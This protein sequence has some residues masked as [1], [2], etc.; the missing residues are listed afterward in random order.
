MARRIG[1]G[2]LLAAG[3]AAVGFFA[4]RPAPPNPIIGMVR[5]TEVKIAPEVSGRIA[6]L[7]V[8]AGDLVTAGT[9]VAEL[10]N[11]ELAA[12]VSEAEAAVLAARATRDRVYAGIRQEEVDIAAH[13]IE[14][15]RAD[16]TLAKAQL[17]R[18]SNL[19]ATGAGSQ[20]Q[21]DDARAAEATATARLTAAQLRHAEAESG[22]TIEE[23]AVADA[24]VVVAEAS[25]AVLKQRQGKLQI[26]S[27]TDGV[28]EVVVGELGEATVPGRTILTIADARKFWFS[29]NIREDQLRGL[30]IGEQLTLVDGKD[31]QRFSAQVSEMR[32]LGD[33]ATWRAARAVGD[34]DLNTFFIRADGAGS[35]GNLEPGVTL[36][37]ADR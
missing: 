28:V 20:Q 6:A 29:F 25:L 34:H 12:A 18:A 4:L 10:S 15:A 32:R 26:N 17:K 1:I 22:P 35:V 23:R 9:V 19:A 3:A 31:N 13:D 36:W 24:G 11:P 5:A 7:P 33:F 37:I 14:K 21:L 27:P 2:I 16:L 8:K 30:G